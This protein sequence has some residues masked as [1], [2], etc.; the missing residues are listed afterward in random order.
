MAPNSRRDLAPTKPRLRGHS[1]YRDRRTKSR[2]QHSNSKGR[3]KQ[4]F[5][6]YS[7]K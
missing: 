1:L 4:W 2:T 5:R 3:I 7:R 6:A